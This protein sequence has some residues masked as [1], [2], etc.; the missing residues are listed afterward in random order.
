MR[1]D[2]SVSQQYQAPFAVFEKRADQL[3]STYV[4]TSVPDGNHLE[5][6]AM[7]YSLP[8]NACFIFAAAYFIAAPVV[9]DNNDQITNA[10][11]HTL[12]SAYDYP[13]GYPYGDYPLGGAS[14]PSQSNNYFGGRPPLSGPHTKR[15][16]Q[17]VVR[18][19]VMGNTGE[20]LEYADTVL[21]DYFDKGKGHY[22]L[23]LS[24]AVAGNLDEADEHIKHA[25]ETDLP[26]GRFIAGPRR[27]F[28]PLH[29]RPVYQSLLQRL[30]H[31][32]I[33]GP[34]LGDVTDTGVRVWVRTAEASA[35]RI[36]VS[37]SQ[38]L[39]DV[40][41]SGEGQTSPDADFTAVV[42]IEGLK[43]DTPYHYGVIIDD[44]GVVAADHQKFRTYVEPGQTSRFT[45]AF[46]G[47]AGYYPE[48]E[49][50]WDTIR[51]RSPLAL[52]TLGD[53]VYIDDP[54]SP[55]MNWYTYYQR[56]SRPEFRRLVGSTPVYAIWDDHDFGADDSWGGPEIDVPYWKPMVFEIFKQ[57]WAN[58]AYGNGEIPGVWFDFVIADVHFIMLD[59]RYYREDA[60]R[61]GGDGVE[62]PSMLGPVQLAW[63]KQ[64]LAQ[65]EG[66]F[67]VLISPVSWHDEAKPGG[68]GRDTWRGYQ[69][70]R[71]AIFS[72]VEQNNIEGVFLLSSDRHRSDAW[73]HPRP[74]GY[75][76]YEF[77]SG[78]FVDRHTHPVIP[79]SLFGYND[80]PSFGLLHFDTTADNPTLRY[81]IVNSDGE[82][83]HDFT[84][85]RSQ[86]ER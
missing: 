52:L 48:R 70:E 68:S 67:K 46:G 36:V 57:N 85:E 43:P 83:L 16:G 53:N 7:R 78:Q 12:A 41:A 61:F 26:P 73:K 17:Y 8:L 58:P 69:H 51:G 24:H 35:V 22:L 62:K 13:Y 38:D 4:V 81:E 30:R 45:V 3:S 64:T 66:T 37:E 32:P 34:L 47:C 49:D 77:A 50:M 63:L 84:L 15:I 1:L 86:L 59:G 56:Q 72:F 42:A 14:H 60:G 2:R 18:Q 74:D 29:D 11:D 5:D 40:V 27:M 31:Q 55:D 25:L 76:L 20:A 65:S 6:L 44:G 79:A 10:G 28:A 82:T 80:K 9:A 21:P 19:L 23:A 75:D 71:E 39:I 33:H 54:E